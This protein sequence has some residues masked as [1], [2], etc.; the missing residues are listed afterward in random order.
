MVLPLF[1]L[2][3]S[4]NI[5]TLAF[6]NDFDEGNL[7]LYPQQEVGVLAGNPDLQEML[8][9]SKCRIGCHTQSTVSV[10]IYPQ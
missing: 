7:A 6:V 10:P 2:V 9:E 1:G 3:W 4:E 5:T 8:A